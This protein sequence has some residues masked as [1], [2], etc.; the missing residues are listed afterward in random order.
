[1]N[2][3]QQTLEWRKPFVHS[4]KVSFPSLRAIPNNY[5]IIQNVIQSQSLFMMNNT[6]YYSRQTESTEHYLGYHNYTVESGFGPGTAKYLDWTTT[7]S[8]IM[9]SIEINIT[10]IV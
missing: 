7:R 1:M 10:L 9:N 2:E 4:I 5:S 6:H 3:S 8:F